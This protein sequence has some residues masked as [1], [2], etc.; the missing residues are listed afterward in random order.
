LKRPVSCVLAAA[1]LLMVAPVS[2]ADPAPAALASFN[3]PGATP[4]SQKLVDEGVAMLYGFNGGQAR[5]KF[6]AVTQAQ[7]ELALPY[8]LMAETYTIDINLPWTAETEQ[9]G[10]DAVAK[11]VDA[12]AKRPPAQDVTALIAALQKRFDPSSSATPTWRA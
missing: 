4:A 10:R 1:F 2:A 11:A 9:P 7:P 3:V 8:A 5:A 12:A 6:A